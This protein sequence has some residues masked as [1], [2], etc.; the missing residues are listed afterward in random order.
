MT[1]VL[2]IATVAGVIGMLGAVAVSGLSAAPLPRA[3]ADR[4]DDFAGL[5]VHALYVLPS[6]GTDRGFDMSG[7][8][9]NSAAAFQ[10]WLGGQTGDRTLRLDTFQGSL[11]VTFHRLGR[12]DSEVRERG[13]FAR[14]LLERDLRMAG[15]VTSKKVY[16]VYYDG[17]N[18]VVCG[19][20]AW[21]PTLPGTVAAFYLRGE[22]PGYPPCFSS[23]FA[24]PG[25]EA[26][27]TEFAMFH[28]V[29]HVFGIVGTC[30][31]HHTQAGHVSETGRDLMYAGPE[32]WQP[33]IL[34]VGRD[35]YFQAGI[36]GCPDLDTTGFLRA[37]TDFQLA[38]TKGGP[39]NGIVRSE[40]WAVI[41]CGSV[42]SAPYGRGT[43]VTLRARGIAGSTFAGWSGP[44]SGTAT[45]TVT[46]KTPKRV[47]ARFNAP[48]RPRPQPPSAS[49]GGPG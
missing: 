42:C 39:G 24:P 22:I 40:P 8:I 43:V 21:P 28:D 4:P 41:D 15:L 35:D 18:S 10:R 16:A 9:E 25:G 48:P 12:S 26:R 29:I 46:M 37:D 3:T 30:A 32:P 44:C 47:I 36:A 2:V 14:D 49:G 11:D 13:V 45:C 1:R 17:S 20:A 33:S 38:V 34:D 6:D 27:Y 23:G 5:Q 31:P 7:E 19:G